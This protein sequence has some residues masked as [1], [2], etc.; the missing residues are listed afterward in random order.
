MPTPANKDYSTHPLEEK[1]NSEK[2]CYFL[3]RDLIESLKSTVVCFK[4]FMGHICDLIRVGTYTLYPT[5]VW[6]VPALNPI[7]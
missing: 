2:S 3:R 4:V 5:A 1:K 7:N 6:L